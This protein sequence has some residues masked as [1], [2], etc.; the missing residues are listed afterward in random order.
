[1]SSRMPNAG[2]ASH[3]GLP[4]PADLFVGRDSELAAVSLML[5][6]PQTRLVT[7]T[8]PPGIGKTRLAVACAS[9]HAERS[10]CAAVFVDL[11]PVRDPALVMV[12]LA[13]AV[14]VEPR[15]GTDLTGQLTTAL[16]HEERLVVLDNCEH[17]LAAAPDIG[18]VLA[19]CPR[20]RV[21]AT[22][23]ERLRLSAEQEFPVPPL[24]IPAPADVADLSGLA[25]NPSVALL[26]DRARRTNPSFDLTS[27]NALLLA[28][29]CVRLEGLPLAI[30]LAAAR[31]KVLTPGELLFRLGSRMEVLAVS[32]RDVPVRQRALRSAIAWSY[33]LLEPGE[34]ALFCKL[35]VF[36]GRW[37]LSDAG[38]VCVVNGDDVLAMVE[39]LLDKSLIRRL[40]GDE[41]TAEFSMLE[42]LR[43]YAAEQLASDA[44]AEETR[45]RHAEHYAG[46]AAEFEASLGRPE[47]QVWFLRIG[48]HH[49]DLRA[50]LD[51]C[52]SAGREAWAVWLATA[53]G[54]YHY[55]HG[56]LAHGQALVDAVLS[57][58]QEG[59][60]PAAVS[61]DAT[62]GDQTG[63]LIAAGVLAWAT[64]EMGRAQGLLRSAL[65]RSE[66]CRAAFACAFLGHVARAGG[67][68]DA[69]AEWH[70]RAEARF[71]EEGS[72]QG[73][74]WARHDLGL[75]A[76]DHGDLRSAEELLRAS[77]R[78]FRELD[79]RWAVASSAWGLGT[80]LTA[81]GRA[82]EAGPLLAEALRIYT[83]VNDPRS[84]AQCLEALAHV[85]GE[86]AHYESAARLIG[87]AAALR[88]RVA[89]RQ[90]D[91]EQ[92]RSSA[93][94]RVLAR[95]LGPDD[96]DRLTHAG[97]TMPAEQAVDLAMAVASGAAPG[98]PDR[99]EQVPLTPRERQVA[100]LVAS[101][102]TN[103]QIGRVLGISEKTAEVH[104]H[105]VMSKLDARSR[106]EVA[107]WAVTH[108]LSAPAP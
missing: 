49:A 11:A 62:P 70:R 58:A 61:A 103:R 55:T 88:E 63:L 106:A 44:A 74:A 105:H 107:A 19:A 56:D 16:G 87:A 32:T 13:Q 100:A 73:V 101:G 31:L 46:L 67:Q 84:V 30:E 94:E 33:D 50:A 95:A 92:A 45:A 14:G 23:R 7:L 4:S 78:D 9:A 96:A 15:G 89:A 68:W 79:Y 42:S 53:L 10:G 104:L 93:V 59:Y 40:P 54:W 26:L 2:Q 69:S 37:T 21:L 47:E 57:A 98:D 28:R 34:R 72:T 5:A 85:A 39:S 27:A 77:L 41:Q 52:L 48:R 38:R 90:P 83:D 102:R 108:H 25:A 35:S 43:E 29:A 36:A 82:E 97:R 64:G 20:L 76:R 3:G 91:T 65:E 17:L 6:Q 80:T 18:Q 51:Y 22:S 75:L 60:D 86:R 24:A 81:L 1:M 66:G 8:G 71:R 12:E 99:P